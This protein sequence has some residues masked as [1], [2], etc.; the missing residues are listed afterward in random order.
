MQMIP[1][2]MHNM[3]VH[4]VKVTATFLILYDLLWDADRWMSLSQPRS[5]ARD[6]HQLRLNSYRVLLTRGR[7]GM[8]LFVPPESA[9]GATYRALVE[10][11][12]AC[13]GRTLKP[14]IPLRLILRPS[15]Q[16]GAVQGDGCETALCPCLP[17][18]AS[19][20]FLPRGRCAPETPF[21][22]LVWGPSGRSDA[23]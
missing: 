16:S 7:D 15:N 6:P 4:V 9:Q 17:T 1:D 18:H 3:G 10:A 8:V 13:S 23:F 14:G 22:V 2:H 11:G 21:G 20:L 5:Q 12:R 19:R